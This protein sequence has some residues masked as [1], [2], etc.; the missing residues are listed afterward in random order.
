MPL[1]SVVCCC[2]SMQVHFIHNSF[3][4]HG[5]ITCRRGAVGWW[6]LNHISHFACLPLKSQYTGNCVSRKVNAKFALK[7]ATFLWKS[8]LNFH[9]TQFFTLNH[10]NFILSFTWILALLITR[11]YMYHI[12]Q[13]WLCIIWYTEYENN[14]ILP[15]VYKTSNPFKLCLTLHVH[16]NI[17]IA[18]F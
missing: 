6:H 15:D 2:K 7:I 11:T 13:N 16:V 10:F 4:K 5:S 1:L 3:R 9:T 12:R 14:T 18:H 8:L 17:F